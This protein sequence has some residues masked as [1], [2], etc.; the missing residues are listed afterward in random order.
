MVLK[1]LVSWVKS[2]KLAALIIL[3]LSVLYISSLS[4]SGIEPLTGGFDGV[5]GAPEFDGK[6]VSDV[7]EG[8]TGSD[9]VVIEESALS[10]VVNDVSKTAD[11][12]VKYAEDGGGFLVSSEILSPE[13]SPVATVVVRVPSKKLRTAVEYYRTLSVKVASEN[14]V[15][16]DVTEEF[17]DLDARIKTL[18]KTIDQ[19]EAIKAQA[20]K[21]SDLVSITREIITI[22]EEIDV[23]KGQK[24]FIAESAAFSRITVSLATDEFA[25]PYQPPEGFRPGVIFKQAVRSLLSGVYSIAGGL[26]WVGV[27]AVVA[28]PILALAWYLLKRFKVL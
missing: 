23:L 1:P 6:V 24:K 14:I 12:V 18:E 3:I 2:N 16:V 5:G 17:K 22:R 26:I 20:T 10:L 25:L 13:E 8:G 15:G 7:G 19:F 27:Y 11:A 9:R 28:V 4:P 21:I